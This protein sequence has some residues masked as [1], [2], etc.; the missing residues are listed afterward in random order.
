MNFQRVK[1]WL[2][3][4]RDLSDRSSSP[5]SEDELRQ[6]ELLLEEVEFEAQ[7]L[8]SDHWTQMARVMHERVTN[9]RERTQETRS[10]RWGATKPLLNGL[11]PL[12]G[13]IALSLTGIGNAEPPAR[14][15]PLDHVATAWSIEPEAASAASTPESLAETAAMATAGLL[16]ATDVG[17]G[18]Q[19]PRLTNKVSH[20]I[21]PRRSAAA[22]RGVADSDPS[23]RQDETRVEA[24][25]HAPTSGPRPSLTQHNEHAATPTRIERPDVTKA[26]TDGFAEQL[27]A[28]KRADRALKQ[29]REATAKT[30]LSRTFSPALQLHADALRAV[31]ACQ[32]GEFE[33][34]KRYLTRQAARNPQSPYLHRMQRA[35]AR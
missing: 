4:N 29:G 23:S 3:P 22:R 35:C 5:A 2:R 19:G 8:P 13:L 24:A 9:E 31:L 27:A 1:N 12:G 7:Q 34:G 6:L 17:L 20:S 14:T 18:E 15:A 16:P 30:A 10:P 33:T 26:E 32:D 11:V 21:T 25:P 28:L